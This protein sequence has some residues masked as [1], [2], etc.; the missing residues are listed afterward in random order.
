MLHEC[1]LRQLYQVLEAVIKTSPLVFE[2]EGL[3]VFPLMYDI[4]LGRLK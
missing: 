1:F 3:T 4:V 2:N